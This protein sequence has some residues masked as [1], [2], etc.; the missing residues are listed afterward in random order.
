MPTEHNP[1][2][3][4]RGGLTRQ[5][6]RAELRIGVRRQSLRRAATRFTDTLRD[7][8]TSPRILLAAFTVGFV[9]ER[10]DAAHARGR[11]RQPGS[12]TFSF[13][14]RIVIAGALL[15]RWG[16][17]LRLLAGWVGARTAAPN[18]TPATG[19]ASP[20]ETTRRGTT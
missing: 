14:E 6:A 13:A 18:A 16:P 2:K 4:V 20:I 17:L 11:R 3:H 10:L 1:L 7:T 9:Y 8:L 12:R 19:G 5:I 15:R